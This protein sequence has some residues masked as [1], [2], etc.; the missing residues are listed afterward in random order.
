MPFNEQKVFGRKA[1]TDVDGQFAWT[2]VRTTFS[3]D[4][5]AGF[6]LAA[7]FIE[8]NEETTK[9]L[10]QLDVD[11]WPELVSSIYELEVTVV[12]VDAGVS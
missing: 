9:R 1:L 2:K 4:E 3:I 10:Q 5:D 7:T 8:A 11:S 6:T 12:K